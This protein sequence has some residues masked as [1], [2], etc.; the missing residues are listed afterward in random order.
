MDAQPQ[1]VTW[2]ELQE[3]TN[4][5]EVLVKL[6]EEIQRGMADSSHDVPAELKEFHRYRH[7]LL[8]MDGVVTYKQRLVVPVSL[9]KRV[10]ETLHAAHQGV[11]G[12]INRA[13]QSIFWPSITTD[14]TRVRAMCR[15]C[16]R[17]SP[18]QPAGLPVR[19]PSPSYPFQL[20]VA[21]YCHMNGVNYLVIADRYSGWLSVMYVGKGEFD[22]DKL[23]DVL[24]DYFLTFG[25]VEEISSDSASQF[26]SSKFQ[27]F[28]RQYGVR[29]RLSSS[30]FPHS[31][32][33]AELG[34][35][36]G[37]RILRDNMSPDGKVNTDKFLRAML[38]YRNT[39]QPDTRMSPAQ[40]VFGRYL[41][42][43]IPVVNDKYEP[44]Q[45]WA[46]VKEYRERALAR[47][48]D[49][50]GAVLEKHTKKLDMIPIGHAVAVQNQK[51][52][53]PK[54]WDKTG[55]VV[56]N[57]DHDKVL[58]KMDGSRRLTTRNRRFVK[59]IISPQDLP[60]QNVIP[61]PSVPVMPG[62]AEE[63]PTVGV[64]FDDTDG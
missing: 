61:V 60:D 34:V 29:H 40:I 6:R 37:K 26:M 5:D 21:D 3:A 35:K 55:V 32:S 38:Q 56:E 17:N 48:L 30:Y 51:G 41:R 45:E 31:N 36:S 24:R 43:F 11:S 20:V 39:P 8:V 52:R 49:R 4:N 7:G 27:K 23:I 19:P 18:S 50:D 2:Q 25:V 22:S 33:R 13:E 15:T 46:M 62:A 42:D 59:K 28:L 64:N 1:M 53:F 14:I 58:V 10:L 9:Q 16:V 44:K 63:V 47:R 57:M 12:M 54:K